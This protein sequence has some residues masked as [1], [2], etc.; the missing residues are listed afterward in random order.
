MIR[1][2]CGCVPER[3]LCRTAEHLWAETERTFRIGLTFGLWDEYDEAA[4]R[5]RAHLGLGERTGV[6]ECQCSCQ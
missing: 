2:P 6:D 3:H 1:L 4:R 5:Y